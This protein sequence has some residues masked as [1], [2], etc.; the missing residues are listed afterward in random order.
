MYIYIHIKY[1]H[2]VY[3]CTYQRTADS[4]DLKQ[5][6]KKKELKRAKPLYTMAEVISDFLYTYIK[7]YIYMYKDAFICIYLHMYSIEVYM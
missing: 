2:N 7:L 1:A 5:S 3:I 6:K 4:P